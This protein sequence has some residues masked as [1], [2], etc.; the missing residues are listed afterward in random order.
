MKYQKVNYLISGILMLLVA[1]PVLAV[2]M[3][4]TNYQIDRDSINFS[5]A[6]STSTNYTSESTLGESATGQSTSTTY[7]TQ[8]GYQQM[9]LSWLSLTVPVSATLLPNINLAY[10]GIASTSVP[11][12]VSTN[13]G[14]GYTM[15]IKANSIH[16]LKS[17][18]ANFF[19][20]YTLAGS[21]PDFAWSVIA[22]TAE[23]GFTPEGTDIVDRYRDNGSS[24]NQVAG[25]DTSDTCWDATTMSYETIAQSLAP[26][27]PI[28]ATTTLK[29]RAEA[30]ASSTLAVGAYTA[31]MNVVAYTN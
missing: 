3:S 25:S 12:A 19:D 22:T 15:Q 2:V 28:G 4:S 24:C 11:L 23:F 10:G 27:Y 8:A 6:L 9:E 14:A 13:N 5:G 30:G 18:I 29:F 21:A 26:N 31:E 7:V 1:T 16:A 20:D 17:S